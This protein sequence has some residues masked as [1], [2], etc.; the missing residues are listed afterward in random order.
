MISAE[1]LLPFPRDR[2]S[3][4]VAAIL[5]MVL[6][7]VYYGI[8]Y[9]RLDMAYHS[10][11]IYVEDR[12]SENNTEN[13]TPIDIN[14][15]YPRYVSNITERRLL[16][17]VRNRD[18]KAITATIVPK[19]IMDG[20]DLT[21]QYV[22]LTS[23]DSSGNM[24][25]NGVL[26]FEDVQPGA[27]VSQEAVLQVNGIMN[28]T[29]PVKLEFDLVLPGKEPRVI[30][31]DERTPM[32]IDV[33]RT[34]VQNLVSFVLLPP[35]ANGFIP[36]FA[37][38]AVYL[39]GL[40]EARTT[41]KSYRDHHFWLWVL[42]LFACA[43]LSIA[44]TAE[45]AVSQL[46]KPYNL[47]TRLQPSMITPLE[48]TDLGNTD[49]FWPLAASTLMLWGLAWK[50]D[51]DLIYPLDTGTQSVVGSSCS[52]LCSL[53]CSPVDL[54]QQPAEQPVDELS[55][56]PVEPA[57]PEDPIESVEPVESIEPPAKVNIIRIYYR[58]WPR[59]KASSRPAALP[60]SESPPESAPPPM[61]PP[62]VLP[63]VIPAPPQP[64]ESSAPERPPD[65][66]PPRKRAAKKPRSQ[67]TR[68]TANP[69]S[70]PPPADT[71]PTPMGDAQPIPD[72]P[73][74]EQP[75]GPL[76]GVPIASESLHIDAPEDASKPEEKEE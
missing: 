64:E 70:A 49:I 40:S 34:L 16:V 53:L 8:F 54:A 21:R 45:L 52:L 73:P 22:F 57:E 60:T 12:S 63:P 5:F 35:W 58:P 23:M 18:E 4:V 30:D 26:T 71:L 3:W 69:A 39:F 66:K 67:A 65:Q 41:W 36:L 76:W 9:P 33:T 17:S 25:R 74:R 50:V 13:Q 47:G 68:K 51:H 75:T 24:R 61:A 43:T 48:C 37:L 55:E 15:A 14:L 19:I 6:M 7:F 32:R 11:F 27:T 56:K 1:G 46:C 28:Q 20:A 29:A 10:G 42:L 72:L 38:F 62:T 59:H 2:F 31:V 44:T